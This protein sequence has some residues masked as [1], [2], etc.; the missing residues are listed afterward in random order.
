MSVFNR[1]K[2]QMIS[3]GNHERHPCSE[4]HTINMVRPSVNPNIM[5][6]QHPEWVNKPCDCKKLIFT[7]GECF[8]PTNK[9]W[10]I[11]WQP[12]PNY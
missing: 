2:K 6:V 9:H 7:E 1:N 3:K 5:K 11:H 12:N 10:E 4:G 8:C